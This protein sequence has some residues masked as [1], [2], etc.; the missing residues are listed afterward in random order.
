MEQTNVRVIGIGASAG[1]LQAITTLFSQVNDDLGCAFVIVQHLSPDFKSHMPSLL[2]KHTSMPIVTV[3]KPTEI[4][5]N[6][7]YL[8]AN[9]KYIEIEGNTLQPVP[10]RT[11]DKFDYPIDRF[12]KSLAQ[13]RGSGAIAVILSGSGTDGSSGCKAVYEQGGYIFV[14][15]EKTAQFDGMPY[16]AISL[17][18]ADDIL[19]P[20]GIAG[21][22]NMVAGFT[23]E[24]LNG[25][26]MVSDVSYQKVLRFLEQ[27]S[28]IDFSD[29]RYNTLGR[30]LSK[31]MKLLELDNLSEYYQLLEQDPKEVEHISSDFLINVTSFFRDKKAYEALKSKVLPALYERARQTGDPVRVW[32]VGCA[33]GQEAYSIAML[34]DQHNKQSKQDPVDFKVFATDADEDAIAAAK[35]GLYDDDDLQDLP[36]KVYRSYFEKN[37]SGRFKISDSLRKR[38]VFALHNVLKDP[39]FTNIDLLICRNL[40]IYF[41]RDT[42]QR[43]L[44]GFNYAVRDEGYIFLGSSE[45]VG[46]MHDA[47]KTVSSRWNIFQN[48]N[49]GSNPKLAV[50]IRHFNTQLL[51]SKRA[52]RRSQTFSSSTAANRYV[53]EDHFAKAL[54]RTFVPICVFVDSGLDVLYTQGPLEKI[55]GFPQQGARFNLMEMLTTSDAYALKR[56]VEKTFSSKSSSTY[57][58]LRIERSDEEVFAKVT[59]RYYHFG[60]QQQEAVLVQFDLIEDQ[61]AR[62]QIER[63][64]TMQDTALVK[65]LEQ[66]LEIA[67]R[68]RLA[69][70]NQLESSNDELQTSN[71]ELQA[72]NEELQSTNEELQSVNEELYTVNTELQIK[73]NEATQLSDDLN[74]LLLST[75]IGMIFMDEQQ[76]IRKFTPAAVVQFNLQPGDIGRPIEHLTSNLEYDTLSEDVDRVV[77]TLQSHEVTILNTNNNRYYLLRILPYRT[78]ENYI[79]GSVLSFVEV[80]A[81]QR[82]QRELETVIDQLQLSVQIADISYWSWHLDSGNI[83][84]HGVQFSSTTRDIHVSIDE[85]MTVIHPDDRQKLLDKAHHTRDTGEPYKILLRVYDKPNQEGKLTYV[86]AKAIRTYNNRGEVVIVGVSQ[87]I[88]DIKRSEAKIAASEQRYRLITE[89]SLD[90]ICLHK[91]D[92]VYKWVSPS[93]KQLLGYTPKELVGVNPYTLFH[94]DDLDRIKNQAHDPSLDGESDTYIEYRMRHKDG[95]YVWLNTLTHVRFDENDNP[96]EIQTTSR[97][98]SRSKRT[99]AAL[100]GSEQRF[101]SMFQNARL[102]IM[103]TQP[104]M[105]PVM[106]ND[107]Y[108]N[109]FGYS[110]EEL[111]EHGPKLL[112]TKEE[113]LHDTVDKLS[114]ED[115]RDITVERKYRHKDGHPVWCITTV[116]KLHDDEGNIQYFLAMIQEITDRKLAE[117][118]L[119]QSEMKFRGIFEHA[120]KYI[121]LISPQ[122]ELVDVNKAT[123]ALRNDTKENLLGKP[124]WNT[125]FFDPDNTSKDVLAQGVQAAAT[126][127]TVEGELQIVDETNEPRDL[128]FSL[129]P[130]IDENNDVNLI[131]AEGRDVTDLLAA[132]REVEELNRTL[133]QKVE[134]RTQQLENSNRELARVNYNLDNF[135]YATAHDL[136]SPIINLSTFVKLVGRMQGEQRENM[137]QRI[138]SSVKRLENTLNGLVHMIEFQKNEN[139]I[140]SNVDIPDILTEVLDEHEEQRELLDAEVNIDLQV[141]SIHYIEAY[142]RSILQNLVSNAFKYHSEDRRLRIEVSTRK[143]DQ[144]MLLT[145]QDNGLG[146]DLDRYGDQLFKPFKRLTTKREGNGIGLNIVQSIVIKNGGRIE[147]DS[148]LDEGTRFDL[149]I[150]P[151]ATEPPA[152]STTEAEHV[153]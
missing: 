137:L 2:G 30:R 127:Q 76:R 15:D 105:K 72:A 84:Q 6:H 130:I 138:G 59:F 139:F 26:T 96:I 150:R 5:A 22:I 91:P 144:F 51:D 34:L 41:K 86:R 134:Q 102:G 12:L 99:E 119:K 110:R 151:Y 98:V 17:R 14:Q 64:P 50:P 124:A 8:I 112:Y 82:L 83:V 49:M 135:V 54:I 121:A 69:L 133:E 94:P 87:D 136:R 33:T 3:D 32:S 108:L 38:I 31:R 4:Q 7:I 114:G 132:Q 100:R 40:L 128:Q 152:K 65:E 61:E 20:E 11:E 21:R 107:A 63:L 45:G 79:G 148:H 109:M 16:S 120:F 55:A 46:E 113:A 101:R 37:S 103:L 116:T 74:N 125:P 56:G 47:F 27:K 106:I 92:G 29:Y 28:G 58:A 44:A 23:P 62:E 123:L 42:Q 25:N 145:V 140:L 81:Q 39:P 115:N 48:I 95:E 88:T 35:L 66:E 90:L 153:Q 19:P 1:G 24:Q 146:M 97:D 18:I 75:D 122:G 89:N 141:G 129:K 111:M 104:D 78:G 93:V 67:N 52:A 36:S 126:G 9:D 77:N 73:I 13:H 68:Q 10:R 60:R 43:Q 149:Y 147:V 118:R 142:M 70:V 80:D 53:A 143:V 85:Y 57:D 71:E 117:R 131:I